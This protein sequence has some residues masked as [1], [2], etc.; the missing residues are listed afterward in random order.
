MFDVTRQ[1]LNTKLG[2]RWKS[3]IHSN[4]ST[5]FKAAGNGN[6]NAH[7][8]ADGVAYTN[9]TA[10]H[11]RIQLGLDNTALLKNYKSAVWTEYIHS[12]TFMHTPQNLTAKYLKGKDSEKARGDSNCLEYINQIT[13]ENS[14]K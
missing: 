6:S 5:G 1:F 11:E 2:F 3:T 14:Q 12:Y 13:E 8:K 7:V 10:S 9:G 4:T